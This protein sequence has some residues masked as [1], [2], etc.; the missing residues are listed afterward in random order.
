[1]LLAAQYSSR[2]V[3]D[4]KRADTVVFNACVFDC[5]AQRRGRKMA[6]ALFGIAVHRCLACADEEN[7]SH[8]KVLAAV[9]PSG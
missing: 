1:L 7:V 5:A 8:Q 3:A 2:H 9:R 6:A 4:I